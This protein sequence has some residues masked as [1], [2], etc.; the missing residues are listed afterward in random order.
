MKISLADNL[1]RGLLNKWSSEGK[2]AVREGIQ[3]AFKAAATPLQNTARAHVQQRLK[4]KSKGL[5]KSL[6]AKVLR[7]RG[8]KQ[9][10]LSVKFGFKAMSIH[11]HGG[12]T[13]DPKGGYMVMPLPGFARMSAK[14]LKALIAAGKLHIRPQGK[15]L[16][17]YQVAQTGKGALIG[18]RRNTKAAGGRYKAGSEVAVAILVKRSRIPRRTNLDGLV[19]AEVPKISAQI[20]RHVQARLANLPLT[21]LTGFK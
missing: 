16:V 9:A 2:R 1:D 20:E 21:K 6:K 7:P 11:E 12:E 5:L 14:T 15:A 4:I 18:G 13:W 3:A 19:K 17:V 8:D 10:A